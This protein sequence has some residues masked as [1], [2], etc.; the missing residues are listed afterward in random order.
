MPQRQ[1][2]TLSSSAST[3][4]GGSDHE[5]QRAGRAVLSR[6]SYALATGEVTGTKTSAF[7]SSARRTW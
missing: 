2:R 7:S 4:S 6:A 1:K 5:K 3:S